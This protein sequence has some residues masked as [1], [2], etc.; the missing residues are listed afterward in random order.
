MRWNVRGKVTWLIVLGAVL[1]GV[2]VYFGTHRYDEDLEVL[3]RRERCVSIHQSLRPD[4][5]DEAEK[6]QLL[7]CRTEGW[8]PETIR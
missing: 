2:I 3:D 1:L 4:G 6:A 5:A 8:S 7:R